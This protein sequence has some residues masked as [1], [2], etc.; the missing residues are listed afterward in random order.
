[1]V[2]LDHAIPHEYASH[3]CQLLAA[4]RRSSTIRRVVPRV[5]ARRR[6]QV[7]QVSTSAASYSV[8]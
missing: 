8:R 7:E 6:S 4:S 2:P 5:D 1:M 3:E